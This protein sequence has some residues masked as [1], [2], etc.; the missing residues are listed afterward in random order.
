MH[1]LESNGSLESK[2]SKKSKKSKK[3][4]RRTGRKTKLTYNSTVLET[5]QDTEN[6][7]L[8][9]FIEA[10]SPHPQDSDDNTKTDFRKKKMKKQ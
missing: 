5:Q 7:P 4:K 8:N 1:S 9:E 2:R 10:I 6:L 3:S